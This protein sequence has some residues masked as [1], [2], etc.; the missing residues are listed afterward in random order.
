MKEK[1]SDIKKGKAKPSNRYQ[2]TIEAL[3][4]SNQQPQALQINL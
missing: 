2:L 3:S 1:L 4:Q